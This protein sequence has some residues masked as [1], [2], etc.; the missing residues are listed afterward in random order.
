MVRGDAGDVAISWEAAQFQKTAAPYSGMCLQFVKDAYAQAGVSHSYLDQHSAKD[1]YG[2]AVTRPG[3]NG[4]SSDNIP[5]GAVVFWPGCSQWGH[6]VLSTGGGGCSSSGEAG[7]WNGSP[8]TSISYIN[9]HWCG[10]KP[11]GWIMP[12]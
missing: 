9:D 11:A 12:Y 7:K 2:V 8:S 10:S 1:G 5:K 3:W 4:Y 6:V